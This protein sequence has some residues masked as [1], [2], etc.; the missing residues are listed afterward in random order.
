MTF[1]AY[2]GTPIL[3]FQGKK[4][5][6]FKY[7]KPYRNLFRVRHQKQNFSIF[8]KWSIANLC[9]KNL[10]ESISLIFYRDRDINLRLGIGKESEILVMNDAR[11]ILEFLKLE[12][13]QD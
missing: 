3:Q 9:I 6:I 7:Q 2:N 5:P 1:D 10:S 11:I 12:V 13:W 4:A 8:P